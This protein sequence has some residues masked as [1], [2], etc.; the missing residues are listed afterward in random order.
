M[1]HLK[2]GW[3]YVEYNHKWKRKNRI[4]WEPFISDKVMLGWFPDANMEI[5]FKVAFALRGLSIFLKVLKFYAQIQI[6]RAEPDELAAG[7]AQKVATK[8]NRVDDPETDY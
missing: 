6:D 5:G 4:F 3:F 8:G 2:F 1:F 7:S